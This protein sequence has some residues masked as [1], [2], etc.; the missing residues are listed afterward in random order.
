M[1]RFVDSRHV[2]LLLAALL[3]CFCW[4]A[5]APSQTSELPAEDT[6]E[7]APEVPEKVDVEPVAEDIDIAG[8]LTRILDATGWFQSP[9]VEVDEGVAFLSGRVD[10]EE[11][12][13]WAARLAGKTQDVVAVVNRIEVTQKSM[14]DLSDAWQE[15]KI[16]A[17][18]SIRSLP[19]IILA[20]VLLAVTWWISLAAIAL[21]RWLLKRRVRSR[22]LL[23]VVARAFAIPV[24]LLGL[25]LVL[26]IS[27]L[28]QLAV[29][30]LGG[31]GL[32]G[33]VLG[34]AFR[35]IAENFLSSLLLSIQ[36]PFARG[37]LITV[38]EHQGF[39]QS[40][41]TRSTLLMTLDG[42]HVQIPNS[43]IYKSTITNFTANPNIRSDFTVG[44][45][46]D[47]DIS[48]AQGLAL[49]IVQE[50]P[51]VVDDPEPLVL[52]EE[53]GSA[54]INLRVYYWIDTD[55][56][57]PLKVRSA[58]IRK[59][60]RAF[61]DAGISMPDEAR[62]V[63]F[64]GGVPVVMQSDE[65]AT[66]PPKPEP[67]PEADAEDETVSHAAEGNLKS[68]ADEI[69]EQASKSRDPEAGEDLLG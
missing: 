23:D 22:L 48:D 53:L 8:R 40:V 13:E 31:T 51:A 63:V 15:V 61:E 3:V 66:L 65:Q 33:L 24:F 10:T 29:T 5:K 18:E 28:T 60:K 1:T 68:D 54:T 38:G 41:N 19:L 37:D 55:Q 67:T 45:G 6:T 34:F 11:H 39:V 47:A 14:W 57:S 27:G 30:V 26:K 36:N 21:A 20:I 7:S 35:D 9:D 59:T 16:V 43:T 69:K 56:Y 17:A 52:V 25:Y 49:N 2:S 64:P 44:I 12:K 4:T 32:V 58:I 42:N 62:E 46:Y 50:H